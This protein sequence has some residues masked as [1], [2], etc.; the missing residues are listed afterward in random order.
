MPLA[1]IDHPSPNHGPRRDGARPDIIL[2]HGTAMQSL[3]AARDRL[4]DPEAEVS[5][6]YLIGRDGTMLRL[7]EEERRAWHAGVSAWGGAVDVNSRSIGIELDHPGPFFG[8]AAPAYAPAQMQALLALL[9]ELRAR[10]DVPPER[11]LAH[12]DVAPGRKTDPGERFD[13]DLLA[14]L[15]HALPREAE[16]PA[17]GREAALAALQTLGFRGEAEAMLEAARLRFAPEAPPAA[18]GEPAATLVRRLAAAA[19]R[20]PCRD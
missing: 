3:E 18:D 2:I 4:C 20:A 5:C 8:P 13:W 16:D 15:G 14:A 9:A 1:I 6:H 11:V 19:R 12:S 17:Q 7:V 10:W